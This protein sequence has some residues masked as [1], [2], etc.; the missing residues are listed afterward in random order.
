MAINTTSY[1]P[2]G[3]VTIAGTSYRFK[4]YSGGGVGYKVTIPTIEPGISALQYRYTNTSGGTSFVN[5]SASSTTTVMAQPNTSI[6]VYAHTL[7][8]TANYQAWTGNTT[9]WTV[10]SDNMS[11]PKFYAQHKHA[12]TIISTSSTSN[13]VT[14]KIINE[15]TISAGVMLLKST[16]T[17]GQYSPAINRPIQINGSSSTS[18][19]VTDLSPST[20]YYW[21]AILVDMSGHIQ[22]SPES[23][24]ITQATKAAYG[25]TYFLRTEPD[26]S[27]GGFTETSL[28]G[29]MSAMGAGVDVADKFSI[30]FTNTNSEVTGNDSLKLGQLYYTS[31]A[32]SSSTP[33]I[34]TP[35][36]LS[37]LDH[38]RWTTDS[39]SGLSSQLLLGSPALEETYTPSQWAT[40][41]GAT[42]CSE[43]IYPIDGGSYIDNQGETIHAP[44]DSGWTI[45]EI[46]NLLK[47]RTV[48]IPRFDTESTI[49]CYGAASE[50][51]AFKLWKS[52]AQLA[53]SKGDIIELP[54]W[55]NNETD[56]NYQCRILELNG[57]VA[58]VVRLTPIECPDSGYVTGS[59]TNGKTG[60][61]YEG[62]VFNTVIS[63]W[64]NESPNEDLLRALV[65]HEFEQVLYNTSSEDKWIINTDGLGLTET[66]APVD[67]LM[68]TNQRVFPL[69][70][71]DII[72]YLGVDTTALTSE[73]IVEFLDLNNSNAS[74]VCLMSALEN[75]N[76]NVFGLSNTGTLSIN[77]DSGSI[78]PVAYIDLNYLSLDAGNLGWTAGTRLSS[79]KYMFTYDVST[80]NDNQYITNADDGNL[81]DAGT[82]NVNNE[83]CSNTT[84][85]TSKLQN[86]KA[87]IEFYAHAPT[88]A[89]VRAVQINGV[90]YD[91]SSVEPVIIEIANSNI[92]VRFV[93]VNEYEAD[94][95]GYRKFVIKFGQTDDYIAANHPEFLQ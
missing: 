81:H 80:S 33:E 55:G 17:T 18:I 38:M 39:P 34:T 20:T 31:N 19:T 94:G 75:D 24:V 43:S 27:L 58:K 93:T 66:Y 59:Y 28:G 40:E 25:G 78:Y 77:S 45:E 9:T 30:T 14:C 65:T 35:Y 57:T 86:Y 92:D 13:S 88:V 44:T 82:F 67:Y 29:V 62:S 50:N 87:T 7:S 22:S 72:D 2:N 41:A 5:A 3:Y 49:H 47:A 26:V 60:V 84:D 36:W 42:N 52:I 68:S 83:V 76:S 12:P 71:K 6:Q 73:Q 1:S 48:I 46:G 10:T 54:F 74:N 61:V 64:L 16:S 70:L 37:N 91:F 85:I 63:N 53:P 23:A 15:C 4:R 32:K 89:N 56:G 79:H 51:D 21:M 69:T 95:L 11:L 90:N 8:D